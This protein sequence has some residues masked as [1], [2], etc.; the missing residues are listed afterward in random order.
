V[1]RVA[2][3]WRVELDAGDG[4]GRHYAAEAQSHDAMVAARAATDKLLAILGRK[5]IEATAE[6]AESALVQRVDAAVLADDPEAAL[7][8]IANASEEERRAPELRLR[9]AKID[10]RGG[11]YD[12]ARKRLVALLDEAPPQTAPVLRASILNG[13]G[14]VALRTGK[15]A[16]SARAFDAAIG[17]LDAH[18]DPGELGQAWIGR[19]AAAE[20]QHQFE[21][22][23]SDYARARVVLRQANDKLALL[24]VDANDGF[25]DYDQDRPAQALQSLTAA[26]DGFKRW[27]ALNEAI[28]C[29]IGQ[30]N[31][32]LALLDGRA[33]L[34]VADAAAP[35]TE[36][37]DNPDTIASFA[38]ARGRVLVAVGRLREAR[39]AFD[40]LRGNGHDAQL[41][42]VAGSELARLELDGGNAAA[43]AELAGRGVELLATPENSGVRARAWLTQ[44]RALSRTGNEKV[45]VEQA[46][47]FTAWAA[48]SATPHAE[49]LASLARAE[50]AR[51]SGSEAWRAEFAMAHE[52]AARNDVPNEIAAVARSYADA[53]L[54][55]GD[56]DAAAVE[57]GRITRWSEQDFLCAVLEARLYAALGSNEAWQGALARAKTLA[58]ERPIPADALAIPVST[59]QARRW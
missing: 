39:A 28:L 14:A 24:R 4:A 17:L 1:D 41:A 19:A 11:R 45:A 49:L 51:G 9:L 16:E 26:A 33:A 12:A 29:S 27:G 3:E 50:T 44:V 13:L 5:P 6:S 52:L 38:L 35:L 48:Q 8:L 43:A 36:R 54:A 20:A 25:L 7:A 23:A 15:P 42:A 10:F 21:T 18:P 46:A 47:A 56:L 55:K 32:Y 34:R 57:V 22:A 30:I 31:A 53:L 37:I 2:D 40:E 58:G 59:Q